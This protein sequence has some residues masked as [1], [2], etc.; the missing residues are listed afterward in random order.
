MALI[1][2][3]RERAG[4][5]LSDS[6]LQ[7]MIDGIAAELAAR[8]G[9]VGS[10][11]VELGDPTDPDS[12]FRRTLKMARPIDTAAQLAIVETDPS[13]SGDAANDVVL[14]TGDF[15]VMHGGLTLQRLVGGPNGRDYWAP[16][17]RVTFTPIGDAGDQ[18][19][20][21][22]ATIKLIQ[23][24]LSYRGGLKSEKAGDYQI[25]LSG[26]PVADR[27]GIFKSLEAARGGAMVMA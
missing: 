21:D 19:A 24:D 8:L 22:E 6:E 7:A 17:V 11:E 2:R 14:A 20:R 18:A 5:D 1:D 26:D 13:N 25:T 12:R 10:R 9:P 23:L 16:L 4:S 15:R 3:V 27:E